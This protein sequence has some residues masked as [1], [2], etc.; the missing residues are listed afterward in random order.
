[1][2][3]RIFSL[4]LEGYGAD[5]IATLLTKERVVTPI[6]Y[7]KERGINRSG[8]IPE[9]PPYLWNNS[10]VITILRTQEY[11]GDVI[12]FKTYSKSYKL[13]KRLQND[14]EN[15]AVFK[16]VHEAIVDRAD[17]ERVQQ[18]R[19]KIRKRLKRDGEVNMFSGL[20]KCAD[21]GGNLN[22][23]FRQNNP[24]IE[25]FSCVN[26]NR[27]MKTC[28]TTHCVRVDFLEQAVMQ[29]V[30]R[31]TRFAVGHEGEFLQAVMGYSQQTAVD[32]RAK[33]QRELNALL[34]RDKELDSLFERMYLDS[35]SGK[36]SEERFAKMSKR[37]DSEQAELAIQIKAVR[38]ELDKTSAQSMTTDMFIATVRKY[39]RAKKLTQRMLNELIDYIEVFQAEKIDG[40]WVQRL[41]IHYNCV[42]SLAIPDNLPL[43]KPDVLIQTRK[44][45][46]V[47]YAPAQ[48][49]V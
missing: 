29:E 15:M 1:V 42:G 16:N 18:K 17:F 19:A 47:S 38:A 28:P 46:A 11:C 14:P 13:K 25:Y 44:G 24:D 6:F 2:V 5:Q 27:S 21:C 3:R 26:N 45:V 35:D 41:R 9:R 20:L 48:A 37:Y 34:A 12:N 33:T 49:A 10:T 8:R 7:W 30:R 4:T 31:L 40:V 36:I 23:H 43:P 39:T 22:F 32:R